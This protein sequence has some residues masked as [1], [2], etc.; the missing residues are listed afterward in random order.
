MVRRASSDRDRDL[1]LLDAVI[2][3]FL[4]AARAPERVALKG[5]TQVV[6]AL[7]FSPGRGNVGVVRVGQFRADLG[8][9]RL[10]ERVAGG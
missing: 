9:E 7:A 3:N 6:E 8:S 1:R 10:E 2:G 4:R 5:H